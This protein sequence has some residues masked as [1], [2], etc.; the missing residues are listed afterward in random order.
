MNDPFKLLYL[1]LFCHEIIMSKGNN[2][3]SNGFRDQCILML[4]FFLFRALSR[5]RFLMFELHQQ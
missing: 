3:K 2:Y 5:N 4:R 1:A